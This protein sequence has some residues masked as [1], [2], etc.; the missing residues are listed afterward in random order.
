[1]KRVL[2]F[3]LTSVAA[4]LML[5]STSAL[6]VSELDS[7]YESIFQKEYTLGYILDWDLEE[8]VWMLGEMQK[9]GIELDA[10]KLSALS[11]E[12]LPEST[13][14][15]I[16]ADLIADYY[17]HGR[18]GILSAHDIVAKEEGPVEFW[19]LERY[20]WASQM[21]EKYDP[22]LGSIVHG[23]NILPDDGDI[24]LEQAAAI[25]RDHLAEQYNLT[26]ADFAAM[27]R[28]NKFMYL[29]Y[30]E[31]SDQLYGRLYQFEYYPEKVEGFFGTYSVHIRNDGTVLSSGAPQVRSVNPLNERFQAWMEASRIVAIAPESYDAAVAANPD[32]P[33]VSLWSVEGLALFA[34]EWA[35]QVVL[36]YT[37]KKDI[38]KIALMLCGIPFSLP[39]SDAISKEEALRI[40]LDALRT[41]LN[42]S[43]EL[44]DIYPY[45]S[46]SYREY[47]PVAPVWRV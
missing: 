7:Y 15:Q 3:L 28:S 4:L 1:M 32:L 19:S 14:N 45:P 39:S 30:T 11:Q 9:A 27:Q 33:D 25:A 23:M 12:G 43:D 6:A 22:G 47:D 37:Q 46:L 16:V 8:H 41:Q 31:Y 5:A 2:L 17:G 38:N 36:S 26:E 40:S 20:A 42:W 35:P 21:G 34:E 44:I 13:K 18:D 10:E 29:P 24:A